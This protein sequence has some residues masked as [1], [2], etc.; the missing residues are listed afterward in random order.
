MSEVKVTLNPTPMT[1]SQEV[2]AKAA[3]T[4]QVFDSVGRPI[5]LRQPGVLAQYRLVEALGDAAEN[6]TYLRM[7]LPLIYVSEI[8]GIAVSAVHKKSEVEAL[9]QR[10]DNHGLEAVRLG[11]EEHFGDPDP[12]ADRAAIKK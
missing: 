9:I 6:R 3:Q 8:D 11:L 10:L 7:V 1:P 12:E 2:V 4:F 5:V